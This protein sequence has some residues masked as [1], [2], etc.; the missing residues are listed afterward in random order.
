MQ[1][2]ADFS[3]LIRRGIAACVLVAL[4][5][6]VSDTV[7]PRHEVLAQNAG[8]FGIQAQMI[9]VFS[10]QAIS[11]SSAIF[12]DIGQ[13]VNIL[14]YCD[15]SFIG[16]VDLE[17]SPVQGGT[18]YPLVTANWSVADSKCHTLTVNGYYPQ[19][20]STLTRSAGSMSAWYT[21]SS[22]PVGYSPA[23]I[24]SNG[25]TSP[26]SCDDGGTVSIAS[27]STQGVLTPIRTGD[28]VIVCNFTV[29]FAAAPST[30]TVSIGWST[31]ISCAGL[32]GINYDW[33]M[34]TI[35]ASPQTV[36]VSNINLRTPLS[37]TSANQ[38]LCV[39]NASG[40][41]LQFSFNAASVTGI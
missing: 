41:A 4:V 30:G 20:R 37:L 1:V 33:E 19:L 25:P 16:T 38:Y 17:W 27:G 21:S 14:F 34:N 31:S 36:V 10:S 28:V 39:N 7:S 32:I 23:A 5:L 6:I 15:T 29:S 24:G 22:G 2:S 35:A 11:A 3:R 26:A 40:V 13:G 18:Y 12:N 8:T 9:P